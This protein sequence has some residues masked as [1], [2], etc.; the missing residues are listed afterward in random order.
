MKEIV[1]KMKDNKLNI[2]VDSSISNKE[3]LDI[4]KERLEKLIVIRESVAKEVIL[5]L[6]NRRLNNREILQLFDVLNDSGIF[7]LSKVICENKNKEI[8]SI[9]KG[10][11]RGGQ[12]RFFDKS[13]L[14]I[15][16]I[17]K[18]SK[19][20][21]N[22]NLY[23]LGKI[24]G[25]VEIKDRDSKIYCERINNS[26]V[27][28]ADTYKLYSEEKNSIL[29]YLEGKEIKESNYK[30]GEINNVKSNSCYIG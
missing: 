15:G 27:K 8:L 10:N 22:G 18:G 11:L 1:F 16:T 23:V 29:I 21:V 13:V 26:L 4:L 5:N 28:I 3:F 9:Y 25:D 6:D 19:I 30:K 12:V 24:D 20:I 7:Y 14:F 2:L 17:N